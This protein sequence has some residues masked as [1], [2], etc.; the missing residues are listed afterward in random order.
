MDN[1]QANFCPT[2]DEW[3]CFIAGDLTNRQLDALAQHLER[4]CT[5]MG[6]VESRSSA[7][8]NEAVNTSLPFLQEEALIRLESKLAK[9][10]NKPPL[11][12]KLGRYKPI[13]E[14]WARGGRGAYS[15]LLI[16]CSNAKLR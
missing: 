14:S 3:D 15:S 4:C 6:V 10:D 12:N 13:K 9:S 16:H 7:N 5:C 1:G 2:Q 8:R 11:P